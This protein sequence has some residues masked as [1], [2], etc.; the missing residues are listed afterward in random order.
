MFCD[1]LIYE[2]EWKSFLTNLYIKY[3]CDTKMSK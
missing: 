2:K 1:K 3:D